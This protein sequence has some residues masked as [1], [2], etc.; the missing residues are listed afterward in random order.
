MTIMEM[1]RCLMHEKNLPKTFWVEAANTVVFLVNRLSTRA[2]DGK[3][4]YES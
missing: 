1:A 3:T 4:P 2:V